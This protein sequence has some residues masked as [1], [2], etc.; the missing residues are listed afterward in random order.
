MS[1]LLYTLK[2]L[3]VTAWINGQPHG[4]LAT[5]DHHMNKEYCQETSRLLS[6][7]HHNNDVQIY[8]IP[9]K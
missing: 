8:C 4:N 7:G 2:I 1:V 6:L 9:E 5:L 3:Y